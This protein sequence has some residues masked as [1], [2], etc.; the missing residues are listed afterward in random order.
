MKFWTTG[1]LMA[2]GAFLPSSAWGQGPWGAPGAVPPGG[3]SPYQMPGYHDPGLY[4]ELLPERHSMYNHSGQGHLTLQEAF[5]E[6]YVRLDYLHWKIS[7]G[8]GVVLGAPNSSGADISGQDRNNRL[9]AVDP[10]TGF[11]PQTAAV[12]PS[13][14]HN[15]DTIDGL[16]GTVGFPTNV[17]TLEAEI[18]Y[19]EPVDNVINI[20]PFQDT[21]ASG[22]E[23]VIGGMT[24]LTNGT[25]SST[26]MILFNQS[27]T[28]RQET[29]FWGSE[30]NWIF[31]PFT[32]NVAV[33]FSPIIGFRFLQ[34]DDS[35]NIS[36]QHVQSPT[37]TLNH[38]VASMAR[39]NIFGPQVG[40]KAATTMGRLELAAET[41]FLFG[42]NRLSEGVYTSEI[43]NPTTSLDPNQA[44]EA[45]RAVK[46]TTTEFAPLFDLSLSG[47]FQVSP[48]LKIFA[49]Y[50]LILASGLS[51]AFNNIYYDAPSSVNQA[52]TITLKSTTS[53]FVAHGFAVG[54]EFTFR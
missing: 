31:D 53:E 2:L 23:T 6:S 10:S 28:A 54:G 26:M 7:G 49:S 48:N 34:L 43:F 29:Q 12:V 18:F 11:Q 22:P 35:L 25:V 24:L 45:A 3:Y 4:D 30:A 8:D 19:F 16:R 21:L 13:L 52:P 33:E 17:G 20:R 44:T 5:A 1:I 27:Y 32:P 46:D 40:L 51:R 9:P 37:V 41:K 15:Y 39:N 50:E 38:M 42:I 14:N 36:G 47:K